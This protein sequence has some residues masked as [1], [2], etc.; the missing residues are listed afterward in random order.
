M[1]LCLLGASTRSTS[2]EV[3]LPSSELQFDTQTSLYF[4]S[5][6]LKFIREFRTNSQR[7]GILNERRVLD[8][9]FW[10]PGAILYLDKMPFPISTADVTFRNSLDFQSD[11]TLQQLNLSKEAW[12]G[13]ITIRTIDVTPR[14]VCKKLSDHLI[15][16]DIASTF[17]SKKFDP[18]V[19]DIAIYKSTSVDL[20]LYPYNISLLETCGEVGK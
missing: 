4:S 15:D 5:E 2:Y 20:T 19:R 11:V 12:L 1:C 17:R 9:S 14:N 10:H 8:L 6:K 18:L 16:R 3:D 13:L 7:Y